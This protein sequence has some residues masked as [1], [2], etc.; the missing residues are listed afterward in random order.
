MAHTPGD[1]DILLVVDDACRANG[2]GG[3]LA[4][5]RSRANDAGVTQAASRALLA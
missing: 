2:T 1:R 5:A 4:A 3:S